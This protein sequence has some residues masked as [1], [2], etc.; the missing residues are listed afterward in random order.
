MFAVQSAWETCATTAKSGSDNVKGAHAKQMGVFFSPLCRSH[1]AATIHWIPVEER[2][3]TGLLFIAMAGVAASFTFPRSECATLFGW[4]CSKGVGERRRRRSRRRRGFCDY[5]SHAPAW[6]SSCV[7]T[8]TRP[9]P[10]SFWLAHCYA[11]DLHSP[12]STPSAL[13]F[14]L[15]P[16][17]RDSAHGCVSRQHC[18]RAAGLLPTLRLQGQ[19]VICTSSA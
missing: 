18:A 15:T 11:H 3:A 1:H 17:A 5:E 9:R 8:S 7:R 19:R 12:F 4:R 10:S 16:R 6:K 13:L 14:S 2:S